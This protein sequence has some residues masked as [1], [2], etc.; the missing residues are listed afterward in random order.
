MAFT[1]KPKPL[2]GEIKRGVAYP[3]PV[4]MQLS[5][6]GRKAISKLRR[7]GMDVRKAGRNSYILGDDFHDALLRSKSTTGAAS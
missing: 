4:F 7:E 2:R 6:L 5:G 1:A 3:M